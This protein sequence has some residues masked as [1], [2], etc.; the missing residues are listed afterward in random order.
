MT[1]NDQGMK[2]AHHHEH[3]HT[4]GCSSGGC[5]CS[6]QTAEKETACCCSHKPPVLN[7]QEIVFMQELAQRGCLPVSRYILSS[8]TEEEARFEMLAPV[9]MNDPSDGM[10]TVK[11]KGAALKGLKE[12]GLI[13]LDYDLRLSDYD[14]TPYTDAALFAYFKDTVEEGKKRPGFLGDTAAIELGTITLTD[15]GKQ[16][17]EQLQA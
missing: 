3:T 17:A 5:G 16:I 14:Y 1:N 2:S 12:K 7:P 6:S 15:A 9:Y 11:E 8:S 13:S 10:E 4:H